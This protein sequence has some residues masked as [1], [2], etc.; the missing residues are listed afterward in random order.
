VRE[1]V[2]LA[3]SGLERDIQHETLV[4]LRRALT[5]EAF[6]A[7]FADGQAMS[8]D[9]AVAAGLEAAAGRVDSGTSSSGFTAVP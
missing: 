5:A 9:E 1:R 3:L 6:E 7:A 4:E 8:S 2:G